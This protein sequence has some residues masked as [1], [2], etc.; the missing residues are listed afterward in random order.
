[1][2]IIKP[3]LLRK[4]SSEMSR[5]SDRSNKSCQVGSGKKGNSSFIDIFSSN[6]KIKFKKKSESFNLPIKTKKLRIKSARGL[7][8]HQSAKDFL[9]NLSSPKINQNSL[10][11]C[12]STK[13]LK[14]PQSEPKILTSKQTLKSESSPHT[15]S[16]FQFSKG[17]AQK[18]AE[19]VIQNEDIEIS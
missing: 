5:K 12:F 3:V 15:P 7:N 10:P 13:H 17:S 19:K 4:R 14:N 18:N 8:R 1:M 2:K 6:P 16:I 11:K 9:I